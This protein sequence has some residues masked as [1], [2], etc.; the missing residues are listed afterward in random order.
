MD[1]ATIVRTLL[2]HPVA[3]AYTEPVLRM[4]VW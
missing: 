1:L 4:W 3:P 2:C